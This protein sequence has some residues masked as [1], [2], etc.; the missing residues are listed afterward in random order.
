MTEL[1]PGRVRLSRR[2]WLQVL[3]GLLLY[4]AGAN[5]GAGWVVVLAAIV[6]AAVPWAW[7][8]TRRAVRSV[9]VARTLPDTA[10]AGRATTARLRV[11]AHS[12]ARAVVEDRLT[13][14]V[15]AADGL[16]DGAA[17]TAEVALRRGLLAGGEVAVTVSDPFG[18][19][20]A[21]ATGEIPSRC[22]VLPAV[23]PLDGPPLGARWAQDAG[24]DASREGHGTEVIGVREYRFGDPARNV[25][26]RS[27]ARLGKLV[28]R[29]LAADARAR[30]AVVVAP[31]TWEQAALDVAAAVVCGVADDAAQ[32]GLEVA[33]GADGEVTPWGRDAR[34]HLAALPPHEGQPSAR[35]LAPAPQT[36]ADVVLTVS[37]A[38]DGVGATLAAADQRRSLGTVPTDATEADIGAWLSTRLRAVTET[39]G[40]V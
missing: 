19:A 34:A 32:A 24:T 15:G 12:R 33:V 30:V 26:W 9:A 8:S 36:A 6:V 10:V 11:A 21:A 23:P 29:E 22:D 35:P 18:L 3:L 16:A 20:T 25:H 37:S 17:L 14:A 7:W 4:G 27:T 28:V 31:G 38:G 39:A 2:A 13:G 40:V 5:V 1:D